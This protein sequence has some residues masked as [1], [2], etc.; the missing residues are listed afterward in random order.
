MA[1]TLYLLTKTTLPRTI[2]APMGMPPS[3]RLFR[4][5]WYVASNAVASALSGPGAADCA[6][7]DSAI[8]LMAAR[9]LG[10]PSRACLVRSA[11]WASA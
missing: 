8:R 1:R 5:A 6:A 4:A 2:A 3:A 10:M 7:M 11:I 9:V